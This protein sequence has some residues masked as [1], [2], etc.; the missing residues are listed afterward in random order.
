MIDDEVYNDFNTEPVRFFYKI[1]V[2]FQSAVLLVYGIIVS[3]VVAVITG[4]RHNRHKPYTRITQIAEIVKLLR[5]AVKVAVPVPVDYILFEQLVFRAA[6]R[7]AHRRAGKRYARRKHTDKRYNFLFHMLPLYRTA[8]Y[9]LYI[10]FLQP[11]EKYGDRY[12]NQ[13]GSRTE[14]GEILLNRFA[15]KHLP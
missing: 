12:G 7:K 2:I 9:A 4:R 14:T 13:H 8:R 1:F 11:E 15:L 3:N 5:Y 10:V 6:C